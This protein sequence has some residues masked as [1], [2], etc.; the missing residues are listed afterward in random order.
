MDFPS[1]KNWKAW[2]KKNKAKKSFTPMYL[3][4]K[5]WNCKNQLPS[6]LFSKTYNIKPRCRSSN[7]R[8]MYTSHSSITQVCEKFFPSHENLKLYRDFS[9]ALNS[10]EY[11][12]WLP[13]TFTSGGLLTVMSIPVD[14]IISMNPECDCRRCSTQKHAFSDFK[15]H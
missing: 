12:T 6:F 14:A 10:H 7:P 5:T 15:L 2:K 4:S 13:T 8:D 3:L 11:N 9:T 1:T